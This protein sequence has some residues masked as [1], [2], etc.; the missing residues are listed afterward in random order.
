M[1]ILEKS[2]IICFMKLAEAIVIMYVSSGN[3]RYV[4]L[5]DNRLSCRSPLSRVYV[6]EDDQR[7]DP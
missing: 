5:Y 3:E 2:G 1:T 4:V 7:K 6:I